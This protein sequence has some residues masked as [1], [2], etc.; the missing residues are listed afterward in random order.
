MGKTITIRTEDLEYEQIRRAAI[1]E[2]R[3]ISNYMVV[4]TLAHIAE[5]E[6]VSD[7]ETK[8]YDLDSIRSGLNEV[9]AKKYHKVR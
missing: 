1:G 8:T 5:S 6:F 9:K 7:E 4:A 3:T 2:K